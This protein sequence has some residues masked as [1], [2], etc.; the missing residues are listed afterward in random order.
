MERN[1][2][3]EKVKAQLKEKLSSADI[4][5][6]FG[7]NSVEETDKAKNLI[8]PLLLEWVKTSFPE[9]NIKDEE[10]VCKLV[11]L[12]DKKGWKK[13]DVKKIVGKEVERIM[14]KAKKSYGRETTPEESEAMKEIASSVL[15]L[16]EARK[17]LVKFVEEKT[18]KRMPNVSELIGPNLAAKFLS[19]A[20]GLEKLASMPGSTIQVIGAEKS[21]FKHLKKGTNPPKHGILFQSNYVRGA[22]KKKR[23]RIARTLAAKIAIA[24]KVDCY[25]KKEVGEKLKKEL[26]KRIEKIK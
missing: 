2:L 18:K 9:L 5:I 4:E 13:E 6:M 19:I 22:K 21:L 1:K 7:V 24:A 12:G 10:K 20:G 8:Y 14:K 25:S 15:K 26:E 23:G 11:L 17:N 16:I 3:L